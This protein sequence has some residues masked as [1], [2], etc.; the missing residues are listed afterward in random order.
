MKV[1]AVITP[2][3]WLMVPA[4]A[5]LTVLVALTL[6]ASVSPPVVVV[7]ASV[8]AAPVSLTGPLTISA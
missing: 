2:E 1:P 4:E 3:D 7:N 5:R 6:P 8:L